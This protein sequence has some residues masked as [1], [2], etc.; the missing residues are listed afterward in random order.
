ME[1]KEMIDGCKEHT[2]YTWAKSEGLDPIPVARGERVF[3]HT[4][5]TECTGL[6]QL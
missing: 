2:L 6:Q 4:R 5:W 3:L 1:F